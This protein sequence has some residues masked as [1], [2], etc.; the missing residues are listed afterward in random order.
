MEDKMNSLDL[1]IWQASLK[2]SA[3]ALWTKLAEYVP[4]I[5]G[6][7][8]LLLVG[9]FV[10]KIIAGTCRR[11]L[12][13]A[14]L[15][16]I[17]QKVGLHSGLEKMGIQLKSSELFSKALFWLIMLIFIIS[18]SEA[19]KLTKITAT[20]DAFVRYFPNILGAG[21]IFILGLMFAHFIK[22][23]IE[24]YSQK[25]NLSYGKALSAVIHP[26]LVVVITVFAID[27]LKIETELLNR[28]IEITLISAGAALAL[29][30]GFGAKDLARNIISGAYLKGQLKPGDFVELKDIKGQ[31]KQI[32]SINTTLSAESGEKYHI[33]NSSF[34]ENTVKSK[35]G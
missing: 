29:S 22:N 10:S 23:I 35:S 27:Q 7:I 9:Y 28:I 30:F 2:A 13:T 12:K 16:K 32:G 8:L 24:N 25:A 19:L 11:I 34:T 26:I 17:S 15:D 4:N 20:I 6:T 1:T 18:A 3:E 14:G 21:L 5:F 31:I 33:P